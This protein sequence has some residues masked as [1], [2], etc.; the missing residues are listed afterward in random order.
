MTRARVDSSPVVAGGRAYVGSNDGKLYVVDVA[1]GKIVF[2]FEAGGPLSASPR[3]G[4]GAA[5]H[6]VAGR[7]V[8]LSR[9]G[10]GAG[11]WG[12]EAET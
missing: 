2:E 7:E 4:V 3:H 9:I 6:R 5:R 11:S 10:I 1:T 8:V 12:L